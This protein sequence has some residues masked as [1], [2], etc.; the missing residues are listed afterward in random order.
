MD[1][2][3]LTEVIARSTGRKAEAQKKAQKI[4]EAASQSVGLKHIGEADRYRLITYLSEIKHT[5]AQLKA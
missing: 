2:N 5:E 1:T 4:Y 3:T